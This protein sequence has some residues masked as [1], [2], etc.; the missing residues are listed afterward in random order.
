MKQMDLAGCDQL[1]SEIELRVVKAGLKQAAE[2]QILYLAPATRFVAE[3]LGQ[4]AFLPASVTG[5][6]SAESRAMISRSAVNGTPFWT[7]SS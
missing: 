1:R 3:F 2:P 6:G 4:A 7:A 5:T